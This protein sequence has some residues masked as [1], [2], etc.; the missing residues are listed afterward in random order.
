M[1]TCK[2]KFSPPLLKGYK[3]SL[4]IACLVFYMHLL[5]FVASSI[6]EQSSKPPFQNETQMAIHGMELC[7]I[8]KLEEKSGLQGLHNTIT[9][10]TND[11][12]TPIHG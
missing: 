2:R 12:R 5:A 9:W 11:C 7:D 8:S 4:R 3:T 6:L 10:M 1:T